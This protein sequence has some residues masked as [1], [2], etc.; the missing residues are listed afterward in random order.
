MMAR[1]NFAETPSLTITV[2]RMTIGIPVLE[3][4]RQEAVPDP[5]RHSFL[6]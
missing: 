2:A 3:G 1:R 4:R 5:R 6:R